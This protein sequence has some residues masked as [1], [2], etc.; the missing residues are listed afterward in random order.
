VEPR[1]HDLPS[2]TWSSGITT[3]SSSQAWSDTPPRVEQPTWPQTW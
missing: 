1:S 3:D 2:V